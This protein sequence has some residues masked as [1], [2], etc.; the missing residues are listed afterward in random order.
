M[1]H[2]II[3][4]EFPPSAFAG[5]GIGTY[6]AHVSQLLAEQG[7]TV[8]VI[9]Q[10]WPGAPRERELRVGG[11]L[12]VHRVP[13]HEPLSISGID[14]ASQ[15][16]ILQ[17]FRDSP[18][19]A[20]A[21]WWQAAELAGWL[22]EHAA[23]DVIEAQEYEAPTY[24]LMARRAAGAGA[25][26]EVPIIVHL[27][28]PTEF[29][30]TE[31]G[32]D[33]SRPDYL[34]TSLAEEYVIRSAD[35]L[36]CPSRFLARIAES[37]YGLGREAVHV[38]PYP[39]GDTPPLVRDAETWRDGQ[40][41]YI[42]RME[43]RK[44]V[45]EWLDAAVAVAAHN[46]MPRFLFIGADTS[47]S[48]TGDGSVR[49][50]LT[51]RVPE[52]LRPRFV[53]LGAIPRRDLEAHLMRARMAVVP[54]RW[55]NFPFTC[56]EAMASGLPVLA[57]PSG[58]MAEMVEDGRTG[59]IAEG[60]DAASLEAALRRA[61]SAPPSLLRDMGA[62]ASSAIRTLC[63]NTTIVQRS[64]EFRRQVGVR[65]CRPSQALAL[66]LPLPDIRQP[67][68]I[69]ANRAGLAGDTMTLLDILVAPRAQKAAVLR[70]AVRNPRYVVQWATWHLRRL[71]GHVARR[72][73]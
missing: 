55:E 64:I 16:P 67:P 44:G 68:M 45:S 54:S 3:S 62:Q 6:V 26:R 49:E 17:A 28:T 7:E 70:R 48:G 51:A 73:R 5:G 4:R 9:A 63:D 65:G 53:F 31:N 43:P 34:P 58:G 19:P 72:F 42:G 13:L 21:F 24:F 12:I 71:A 29:A 56:I 11:R 33:R 23:I 66:P 10:Q 1:N 2:L 59:W 25:I 52:A 20:Q 50:L 37:R 32:W 22:V 30:F 41:C 47:R 8:H 69:A 27:H 60:A 40:I 15:R 61:L 35:A 38:L 46:P 36:L 39:W 57:S 18:V 14:V